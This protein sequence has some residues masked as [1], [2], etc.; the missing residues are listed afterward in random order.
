MTSEQLS[1][2]ADLHRCTFL[3]G[4]FEKRFVKNLFNRSI[5]SEKPLTEKQGRY[6][7]ELFHKYRKQIGSLEH[8]L[9]CELCNKELA[10]QQKR[11]A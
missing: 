3:P 11:E 7:A 10:R 1:M 8:N 6:L 4:S 5:L 2:I 9:H